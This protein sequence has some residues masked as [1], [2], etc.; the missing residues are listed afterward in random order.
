MSGLD[1]GLIRNYLALGLVPPPRRR[2]GRPGGLAFHREHLD[3]LRFIARALALGFPV[4]AIGE[5]L[6]LDG[7]YRTCGDVYL[8]T[9]RALAAM[10]ASEAAPSS[11]LEDLAAAC[12]QRGG[13]AD[14]PRLAELRRPG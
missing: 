14:C 13:P 10:R 12:P 5:L 11:A 7:S 2:R 9:Q 8:V 6:G 3:R 1:V 4:D